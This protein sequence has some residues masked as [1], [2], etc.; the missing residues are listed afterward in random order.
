MK[1]F[2]LE[3]NEIDKI[4][5]LGNTGGFYRRTDAENLYA[6]FDRHDEEMQ[7]AMQ[8]PGF[9]FQAFDYELANHE[10]V[11]TH[12][13]EDT[14]RA[15]GMSIEEVN[16]NPMLLEALRKAIKAQHESPFYKMWNE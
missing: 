8:E 13:P 4:Y 10:Y 12:N 1:R 3:P 14:L 11:I 15:L 7:K 2:G 5:K 9:A 16:S 6:M